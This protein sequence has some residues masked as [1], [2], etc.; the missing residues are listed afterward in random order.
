MKMQ[1][2]II[3]AEKVGSIATFTICRENVNPAFVAISTNSDLSF[4]N[5][6]GAG[7]SVSGKFEHAH[8]SH[9]TLDDFI[10]AVFSV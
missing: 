2:V 6:S 1:R 7:H 10:K 5:F 8:N 3:T 9:E 4:K